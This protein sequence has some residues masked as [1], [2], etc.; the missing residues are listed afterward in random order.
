MDW[1]SQ[2]VAYVKET[3][4]PGTIVSVSYENQHGRGNNKR[5]QQQ[6]LSVGSGFV[7]QENGKRRRVVQEE[8]SCHLNSN[9]HGS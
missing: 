9:V 3:L 6:Q 5:Q 1:L 4:P 2:C 8:V 7:V